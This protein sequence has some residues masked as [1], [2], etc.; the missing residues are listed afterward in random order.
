MDNLINSINSELRTLKTVK[1]KSTAVLKAEDFEVNL[2]FDLELRDEWGYEYVRST[3]FAVVTI[4]TGG[5]EPLISA[6]LD[7]TSLES[8]SIRIVDYYDY[9]NDKLG[10]MIYVAQSQNE[11]DL[12][13]LRN[14]GSVKVSYK[15]VLT[16]TA[17]LQ[18]EVKYEDLWTD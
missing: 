10:K 12:A 14:G 3:N 8:R 4:D 7:I 17:K 18:T 11:S 1:E 13:T 15:L 6:Q 16:S 2:E 5:L 9:E